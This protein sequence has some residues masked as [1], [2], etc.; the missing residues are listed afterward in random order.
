MQFEKPLN[1]RWVKE[2]K[3]ARGSKPSR[4][5]HC[6]WLHSK[7]FRAV[8]SLEDIPEHV[9]EFFRKNETLH[10]EAFLEED[11]EPSAELV[12][13]IREF[14]ERSER[15]KRMLFIHCSAGATRTEKILRLLKL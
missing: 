8:V 7:G 5:G 13:K 6:N 1:F 12:G 10:L 4:Q 3:I 15:E 2:G 14:L 11:E 9:K